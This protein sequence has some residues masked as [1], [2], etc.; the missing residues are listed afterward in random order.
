M[1]LLRGQQGSF[2]GVLF[3]DGEYGIFNNNF[4]GGGCCGGI[5]SV[6]FISLVSFVNILFGRDSYAS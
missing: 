5:L 3:F 2:F 1:D 6:M 4:W